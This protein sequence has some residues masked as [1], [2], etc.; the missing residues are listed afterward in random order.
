MVDVLR[1]EYRYV[2]SNNPNK[3]IH[4][5]NFRKE[6]LSKRY[7]LPKDMTESEMTKKLGYYKVF[8]CGLYK[9]VYVA[10]SDT[11]E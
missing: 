7:G 4:K 8:D 9:Y 2:N 5:F 10:K 3:R 11:H 1:P 6:I